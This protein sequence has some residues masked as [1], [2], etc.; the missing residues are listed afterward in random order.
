MH[1][2]R[3]QRQ[4]TPSPK[5]GKIYGP[6]RLAG[7]LWI[8]GSVILLS[9]VCDVAAR[10]YDGIGRGATGIMLTLGY[11]LECLAA[12]LAILVGGA[13]LLDYAER[14]QEREDS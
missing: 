4:Q 14:K 8:I 13:L 7:R 5:K 9:G 10:L 11:D 3:K 12:G 1:K 6:T 2:K